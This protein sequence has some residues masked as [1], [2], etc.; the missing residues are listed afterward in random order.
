MLWGAGTADGTD[1]ARLAAFKALSYV[2]GYIVRSLL[3]FTCFF[4]F[5]DLDLESNP[6][7]HL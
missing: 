2:P 3:L 4:P 7:V 1:A 5:L 6:S